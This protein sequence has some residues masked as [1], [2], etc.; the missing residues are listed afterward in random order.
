ML[1]KKKKILFFILSRLWQV[2]AMQTC[3][4]ISAYD[5]KSSVDDNLVIIHKNKG[6]LLKFH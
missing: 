3:I 1:E 2:K 6:M 4:F 5:R